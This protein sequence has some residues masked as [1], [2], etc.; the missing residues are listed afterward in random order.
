MNKQK[1]CHFDDGQ[2]PGMPTVDGQN[3]E[4]LLRSSSRLKYNGFVG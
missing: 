4:C 1:K 3:P 2:N